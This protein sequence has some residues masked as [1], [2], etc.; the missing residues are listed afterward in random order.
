MANKGELIGHK[1]IL[2]MPQKLLRLKPHKKNKDC[3]RLKG[4]LF[5]N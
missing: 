4:F 5:K 3:I 2:K 1:L